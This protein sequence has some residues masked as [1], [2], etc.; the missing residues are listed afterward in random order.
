MNYLS[1]ESVDIYILDYSFNLKFNQKLKHFSGIMSQSDFIFT[2]FESMLSIYDSNFKYLASL[3]FPY[4]ILNV[5]EELTDSTIIYVETENRRIF[6]FDLITFSSIG[7]IDFSSN[8]LDFWIVHNKNMVFREFSHKILVSFKIKFKKKQPVS[9]NKFICTLDPYGHH[10]YKNPYL[11]PCNNR[12]CLDCIYK[13][14]SSNGIRIKCDFESCK[15]KHF[16]NVM[17]LEPD[18]NFNELMKDNLEDLLKSMLLDSNKL[19]HF[20]EMK[21]MLIA[22]LILTILILFYN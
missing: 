8:R 3:M 22:I 2:W 11:L 7:T 17:Q 14:R 18:L 10:L 1:P 4:Y 13:H 12:A 21:S 15:N 5:N 6:V 19:L 20:E 9:S 16:I